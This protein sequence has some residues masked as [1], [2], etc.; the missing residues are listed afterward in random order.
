[1]TKM[2]STRKKYTL[3]IF[4][5]LIISLL[6]LGLSS[7]AYGVEAV[8]PPSGL[9][10]SSVR[11]ELEDIDLQSGEARIR[12]FSVQSFN[13]NATSDRFV[14][15]VEQWGGSH[16]GQA[17]FWKTGKG[18]K[19]SHFQI[20]ETTREFK[21]YFRGSP[22]TYPFD[23][24]EF[25]VTLVFWM[26]IENTTVPL[27][28]EERIAYLDPYLAKYW[29][30]PLD[31]RVATG[32]RSHWLTVSTSFAVQ[33]PIWQGYSNIAPI[34]LVFLMIGFS[35]L[36]KPEGNELTTK[37]TVFLSAF[38]F[39]TSYY[40]AILNSVPVK[41]RYLSVAELLVYSLFI[42]IVAFVVFNLIAYKTKCNHVLMHTLAI[43][44]SIALVAFLFI[45][46]YLQMP[47]GVFPYSILSILYIQFLIS[48]ALIA[49]LF[50]HFILIIWNW[51]KKGIPTPKF[52]ALEGYIKKRILYCLLDSF[53]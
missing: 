48:G 31:V 36:L 29:D 2:T 50:F 24:Y 37:V 27:R 33:R 4:L 13:F 52:S 15:D 16:V 11:I 23:R 8:E 53:T 17:T 18:P 9:T 40:I 34:L 22:E 51:I 6:S 20:N 39:T 21:V 3:L 38:I 47:F 5:F 44:S 12:I 19:F 46:F 30:G 43:I 35:I 14:M 49:G 45:T 28:E 42:S 10:Y 1:M 26:S 41:G 7:K 32:N 25:N